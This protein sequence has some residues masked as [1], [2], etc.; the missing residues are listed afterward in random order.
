MRVHSPTM[1]S[2]SSCAATAALIRGKPSLRTCSTGTSASSSRT[3]RGPPMALARASGPAARAG[4]PKPEW[5]GTTSSSDMAGAYGSATTLRAVTRVPRPKL[6]LIVI[7]GLAPAALDAAIAAGAAPTLQLLRERA[8]TGLGVSAFPSLTPVCLSAI[9]I[10]GGPA[11][12]RIPSLHWYHRGEQRFVEYGSSFE[13]S[14]VA[15]AKQSV[16]DSMLNLNHLH[17]FAQAQDGVRV[18]RGRRLRR[19]IDQLLRLARPGAPPDQAPVRAA[20]GPPDRVLRRRLRRRPG[21]SSASS[22]GPTARELPATSAS[23][24]ATTTTP[25]PSGAGWSPGTASTS[26]CSTSPR[27]T[28]PPTAPARTRS[29]RRWPGPT[30]TW[31]S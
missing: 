11:D 7:D 4:E 22:S 23:A 24:G 8:V 18:G 3:R 9:A 28:L 13:A 19:R 20:G 2:G 6:V 1:A 25:A 16:D 17:L 15:G 31:P 30:T 5:K 21:S 29:P 10:G 26:C 14:V 27:P 12:T